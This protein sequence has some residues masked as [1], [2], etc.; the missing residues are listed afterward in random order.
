[1][2]G[3]QNWFRRVVET[4]LRIVVAPSNCFRQVTEPVD[5]TRILKFL[6]WTRL[7]SW[8]FACGWI[9][10]ENWLPFFSGVAPSGL[11][12]FPVP[13]VWESFFG[14]WLT[15]AL[16][17]WLL[18]MVPIG[19]P[20]LYFFGGIVAHITMAMTGGTSR[21]IG[22]SMRCFGLASA[23][24]MLCS[25]YL[26]M[27]LRIGWIGPQIWVIGCIPA[28]IVAYYVLAIGLARS[29][30][31]SWIRAY[32]VAI[33]PWAFLSLVII[34][35]NSLA[36]EDWPQLPYGAEFTSISQVHETP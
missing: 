2:L 10:T 33:V 25:G 6:A 26:E 9:G 18:L 7:P 3:T 15:E 34:G 36:W 17:I 27:S 35:R 20:L 16:S 12:E 32:A 11:L 1:M 14:L 13:T 5:H 29:H 22:S 19:I 21:S 28:M 30:D 4:L 31:A 8:A 24:L 23:P